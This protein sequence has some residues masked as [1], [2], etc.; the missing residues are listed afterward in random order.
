MTP[1]DEFDLSVVDDFDTYVN[2]QM[3]ALDARLRQA[4]ED[5]KKNQKRRLQ[6]EHANEMLKAR[7]EH[8]KRY[9]EILN[10]KAMWV[11]QKLTEMR[12]LQLTGQLTGQMPAH[13]KDVPDENGL[14]TKATTNNMNN[15][16]MKL[17]V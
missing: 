4:Q 5:R 3:D 13:T 10:K 7:Y 2:A 15:K 6:L 8:L 9:N 12:E 1:L 11:D 17:S 16:R 14:T